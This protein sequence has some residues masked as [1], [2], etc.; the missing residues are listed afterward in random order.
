MIILWDLDMTI[1]NTRAAEGLR[2]KEK[3]LK[4]AIEMIPSFTPAYRIIDFIKGTRNKGVRHCVVTTS[5]RAYV[6]EVLARYGLEDLPMVCYDDLPSENRNKMIKPNAQHVEKALEIVCA[7]ADEDGDIYFI[8]DNVK[9]DL[10]VVNN[11][12]ANDKHEKKILCILAS[13]FKNDA[14]ELSKNVDVPMPYY[15]CREESSLIGYFRNVHPE[16]FEGKQNKQLLR[17]VV[18]NTYQ[19]LDYNSFKGNNSSAR[20]D[21]VTKKIRNFKH[22]EGMDAV[23]LKQKFV[24][25][26]KT[27]PINFEKTLVC[28]VPSSGEGKWSESVK[29]VVECLAKETK[30]MN[31]T[32]YLYRKVR[33]EKAH[34]R[35]GVRS[36]DSALSSIAFDLEKLE[37]YTKENNLA[38]ENVLILDDILTSGSTMGACLDITFD[39]LKETYSIKEG[40]MYAAVVAVTT[41]WRGGAS[42][43]TKNFL[44]ESFYC[45]TREVFLDNKVKDY[46]ELV[47]SIKDDKEYDWYRQMFKYAQQPKSKGKKGEPYLL[48]WIT[49]EYMDS[50][51]P[52]E[53]TELSPFDSYEAAE[54]YFM[55]SSSKEY[56]MIRCAGKQSLETEKTTWSQLQY[57]CGKHIVARE[58]KKTDIN[59]MI[60]N[61]GS[62][63][64]RKAIS[65]FEEATEIETGLELM[66]TLFRMVL[67]ERKIDLKDSVGRIPLD[68]IYDDNIV[69]KFLKRGVKLNAFL[70]RVNQ[71][72][73]DSEGNAS[74]CFY[75][76]THKLPFPLPIGMVDRMLVMKLTTIEKGSPSDAL[77]NQC[78]AK[79][80]FINSV[81]RWGFEIV[82][83]GHFEFTDENYTYRKYNELSS[84]SK[85]KKGLVL[86]D[87]EMDRTFMFECEIEQLPIPGETTGIYAY[88]DGSSTKKG[89][90]SSTETGEEETYGAGVVLNVDKDVFF[91]RKEDVAHGANYAGELVAATIALNQMTDMSFEKEPE[92]V[93]IFFDNTAIGYKPLGIHDK[94]SKKSNDEKED[95]GTPYMVAIDEFRKKYLNTI[96]EFI[97]VDGHTKIMG[98]EMADYIAQVNQKHLELMEEFSEARNTILKNQKSGFVGPFYKS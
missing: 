53:Q 91:G 81:D 92:R 45:G 13:W 46:N 52:M 38:I 80:T 67:P 64:E 22:N 71:E 63:E 93:R 72:T 36:K 84:L 57:E 21:V 83:K 76:E 95:V 10:G 75:S 94:E 41:N 12:N 62:D 78:F 39:A 15:A 5:R 8:G 61:L 31:G 40:N 34:Q 9:Q 26:L 24:A 55:K 20:Y 18:K 73:S 30:C 47:N 7:N 42:G 43:E 96:V 23:D 56:M 1:A 89:E 74:Y 28:V 77:M 6:E 97:H 33:A 19:M 4:A 79:V 2:E 60:L 17:R 86:Y 98:N 50:F 44:N 37:K 48:Q 51:Y 35:A 90:D 11:Y 66:P 14:E 85:D 3:T 49:A 82:N 58:V 59:T 88:V 87:E 25:A 68:R 27:L 16:L 69:T 54:V 65:V 70:P 32:K 29:D